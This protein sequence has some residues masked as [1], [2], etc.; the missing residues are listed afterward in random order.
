MCDARPIRLCNSRSSVYEWMTRQPPIT[1]PDINA[2]YFHT[3]DRIVVFNMIV[4]L[5]FAC[6]LYAHYT[7]ATSVPD[8]GQVRAAICLKKGPP[9]LNERSPEEAGRTWLAR[10]GWPR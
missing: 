7:G 4:L 10:R 3:F 9:H 2:A 8:A 1:I 5:I 6:P